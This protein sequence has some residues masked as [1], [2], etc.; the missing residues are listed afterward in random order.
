MHIGAVMLCGIPA[1]ADELVDS[2]KG[3]VGEGSELE[4]KRSL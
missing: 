3:C 2:G 4:M 1:G